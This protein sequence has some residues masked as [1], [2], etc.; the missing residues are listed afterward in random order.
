MR[1]VAVG[2]VAAASLA[3]TLVLLATVPYRTVAVSRFVEDGE[4]YTLE[5]G[6][7]GSRLCVRLSSSFD[8]VNVRVVI[9]GRA[10]Y[11]SSCTYEAS[12]EH[13][14]GFGYHVIRVVIEN[15]AGRPPWPWAGGRALVAGMVGY[16]LL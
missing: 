13:G 10:I 14:L 4:V 9:D 1:R 7:Y 15:P 2:M 8:C 5:L 3:L 6:G 16:Y 12:I 11:S